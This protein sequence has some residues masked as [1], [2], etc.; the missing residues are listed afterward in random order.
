MTSSVTGCSTCSRVFISRKTNVLRLG[1]DQALDRARAAVADGLAGPHGGRQHRARS[2]AET[3]G[4]GVSSA[5]FWCR[6]CTEQSRS[7][8]ATTRPS[9]SPRIWTSTCRARVDVALEQDRR[10]AEEPLGAGPRGLE[11]RPQRVLVDGGAHPDAAAARG[12]LDHDRVADP[13]GRRDR[14]VGV[15]DRL[16][17]ARRDRDARRRHQVAGADLVAHRSIASGDGPTQTSPAS[18]TARANSAFS[19]RKP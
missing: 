11:R 15:G 13:R 14:R 16:A 17:G 8:S 1:V 3:P 10:R 7:P 2:S 19:A 5:T 9:A 6:R 4:D 12:R 18:V